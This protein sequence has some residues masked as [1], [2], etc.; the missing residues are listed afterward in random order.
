MQRGMLSLVIAALA[1]AV[2]V[3]A[4]DDKPA[5][6]LAVDSGSS[7]T[8]VPS[9]TATVDAAVASSYP[10]PERPVPK[11]SPTVGIY[12]PLETQQKAISYMAAMAAPHPDDPFVD[13]DYVK[14][15]VEKLKPAVTSMDKGPD[16]AKTEHVDVIGGGRRIDMTF[17]LGCEADTPAH[18]VGSTGLTLGTLHDHGVLVVACHDSKAQC[19]QSTRDTTDILCTQAPK[20]NGH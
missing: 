10:M 17:S 19:L 18:A 20:H 11:T 15:L 1:P 14:S 2:F 8:A 13:D 9:T 5:A 6:P 16:K 3:I 12:A 7:T 4:C